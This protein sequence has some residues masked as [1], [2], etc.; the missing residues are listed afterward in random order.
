[1]QFG[2]RAQDGRCKLTEQNIEDILFLR[3]CE[4]Y[5]IRELA[6]KFKVSENTIRSHL[7]PKRMR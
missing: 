3:E 1:M 4:D 7:Y 2:T 5:S 6:K